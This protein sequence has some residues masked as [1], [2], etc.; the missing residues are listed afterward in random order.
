MEDPNG[1]GV[2]PITLGAPALDHASN[3][4]RIRC[5]HV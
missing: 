1:S 5:Q 4:V 2:V 3:E